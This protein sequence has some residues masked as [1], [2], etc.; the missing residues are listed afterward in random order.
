MC[1]R[2]RQ[3][4]EI[5]SL[6]SYPDYDL[7]TFSQR[8]DRATWNYLNNSPTKPMFNRA[9]QS[10]QP[11]GSTWKPFMALMAL[12]EGTLRTDETIFCPGYHP[13]GRGRMFRC[14]HRDGAIEVVTAIQRSC[15]TFFFELMYRTDVNTYQ[16]YAHM[17]GFGQRAVSD[18]SEQE[19]GLMPDS[20]YFNRNF[21]TT[22]WGAGTT[23]NLSLIHI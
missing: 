16:K 3:T 18:V 9:T 6:V 5:L 7:S 20:A 22:G 21:G 8:V 13:L 11:P 14:M 10:M 23:I 19:P 1:I 15:N 4:G 12:Q 2:D 17:F